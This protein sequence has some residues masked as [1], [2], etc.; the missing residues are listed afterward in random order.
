MRRMTS[1]FFCVRIWRCETRPS[2][3]LLSSWRRRFS[4]SCAR[5]SLSAS[6]RRACTLLAA[7]WRWFW[8]RS[9]P[10]CACSTAL[11]ARVACDRRSASAASVSVASAAVERSCSCCS[12]S[13]RLLL[14]RT[15]SA[16][17]RDSTSSLAAVAAASSVVRRSR[18]GLSSASRERSESESEDMRSVPCSARW[19]AMVV[20]ISSTPARM[21][22]SFASCALRLARFAWSSLRAALSS[23]WSCFEPSFVCERRA[24]CFASSP[25]TCEIS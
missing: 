6:D 18:P 12:R 5:R 23:T 19:S 15:S 20:S 16:L 2:I 7:S 22:A 1:S 17:C 13:N 4:A 14:R 10:A 8:S 9:S 21:A 3:S 25:T 24:S 11:C